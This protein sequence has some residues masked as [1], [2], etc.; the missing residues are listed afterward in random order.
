MVQLVF[1]STSSKW[2][3][4]LTHYVDL[5]NRAHDVGQ[6]Q[7]VYE[8]E[9]EDVS[10]GLWVIMHDLYLQRMM[11]IPQL[12][13]A[14]QFDP[15][16]LLIEHDSPRTQPDSDVEIIDLTEE[17]KSDQQE[18]EV[19]EILD[20]QTDDQGDWFLVKFG[21]YPHPEWIPADNMYP[22]GMELVHEYFKNK[23]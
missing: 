14:H 3:N 17:T 2:F 7:M 10:E 4:R 9:A 23:L 12:P 22:H 5:L 19:V 11:E 13:R 16:P 6:V 15:Q 21:G 20:H 1:T 18:Y 8:V